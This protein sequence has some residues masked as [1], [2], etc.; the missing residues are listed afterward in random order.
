MNC[1]V[2]MR[3]FTRF[4]LKQ[5]I[6]SL[7]ASILRYAPSV[8]LRMCKFVHM[9]SALRQAQDD[10]TQSYL[11]AEASAKA[12]SNHPPEREVGMQKIFILLIIFNAVLC[13]DT[14]T[15]Y[16]K[17]PRDVYAAIY[18][19]QGKVPLMVQPE[20]QR[21]TEIR[22]I[23]AQQSAQLNR[24]DRWF[25]YD[26]ELVFVEDPA[27]LTSTLPTAM[28]AT[29]H[30]K[31][32]GNLQGSSFYLGDEEGD[33]YAYTVLEWNTIQIP[34]Q[35]AQQQLF[36]MLP[37]IGHNP[38]K[39]TVASVRRGNGL[40]DQEKAFLQKRS[41]RVAKS[42]M[43]FTGKPLGLKIPTIALVC[44]GGGYRAMLYTTGA[45]KGIL[46]LELMDALS[47][48]VGLSGSTWAIGTWISSGKS[49]N[50]F[51][52]WVLNNIGFDMKECDQDDFTLIGETLLTKYCAG[53]PLGFVDIYGAC[54]ANDLFD[55]F[56][57]SKAQAHVSDQAERIADGSLPLPIYTAVSGQEGDH[58]DLWYDFTPHE[59]GAC[60]M[61]SYVPTWAFGRKFKN[62]NS[63]TYAPEQPMGTLLG[64]FGLAMGITVKRMF[65]EAGIADH[66]KL[67]ILKKLVTRIIKSYGD[68]RPISAEYLNFAY[69]LKDVQ[70]N[71]LTQLH[72]VD[73]G[74]NC[75]LPY[76]PISGQRAARK[77]D[78][79]IFVDASAG[80]IGEELRKAQNYAV[81]HNLPFPPIDYSEI[82]KHAVSIF[83]DENNGQAPLVIYIP[84]IVDRALLEAH[85][86]DQGF[87][88]L[89]TV[90]KNFDIEQ[91]IAH[92]SCNTFNFG[93]TPSQAR[94]LTA[95][96]E[97][98]MLMAREAIRL[99]LYCYSKPL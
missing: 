13:A 55:I 51:H 97:F 61:G 38:Y 87:Q 27:L 81:V 18:Y 12:G 76:P 72:L 1:H 15:V 71:D 52:E 32:V 45:L 22:C 30:A 99:A 54:V 3:F 56:S 5:L 36:N 84:R 86:D 53:Q 9:V 75:N 31:N 68:D 82:G 69:G 47:Y 33:I 62:G 48:V 24:P 96:G 79:I 20:A 16:N 26:R 80:I 94:S 39:N 63:V 46:E 28:L 6:F 74:L 66:M 4:F 42:L 19:Q 98:N 90:L 60:W 29:Y 57:N 65:Q 37:A 58:E 88:E 49:I 23:D 64:T 17:T 78:I 67:S 59:V 92:E 41:S 25:G 21:V 95:L 7:F 44:S 83:K 70:F 93:Y 34:L 43:Q 10:R 11:S 40:C 89:Y 50:V 14:I 77:A 2:R 85:K 35:Y 8:L 91:C 73:A